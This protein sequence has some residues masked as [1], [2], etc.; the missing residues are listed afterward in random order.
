MVQF[1]IDIAHMIAALALSLVGISYEP[2]A[3]GESTDQEALLHTSYAFVSD[4]DS[5]PQYWRTDGTD[6]LPGVTNIVR[7]VSSGQLLH[8]QVGKLD[9]DVETYEI[10]FDD[11]APIPAVP[12]APAL[13]GRV[14]TECTT[15]TAVSALNTVVQDI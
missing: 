6:A 7:D 10:V 8:I 5:Q 2:S 1:L 14:S 4:M 13:S 3:E 9:M 12:P 11:N 15:P